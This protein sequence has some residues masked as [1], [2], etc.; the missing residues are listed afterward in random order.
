MRDVEAGVVV[1]VSDVT[2]W[3][4]VVVKRP[5]VLTVDVTVTCEATKSQK[6]TR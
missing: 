3:L 5:A 4:M 2:F 6:N 1:V